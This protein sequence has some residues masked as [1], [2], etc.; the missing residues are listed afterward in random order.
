VDL[1]GQQTEVMVGD[2]EELPAA[3]MSNFPLLKSMIFGNI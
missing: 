3:V 2:M 1:E